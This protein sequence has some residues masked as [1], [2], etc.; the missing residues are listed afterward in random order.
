MDF[1][2]YQF[3]PLVLCDPACK[4]SS[5]S[6]QLW[7]TRFK[8]TLWYTPQVYKFFGRGLLLWIW[9]EWSNV[10]HTYCIFWQTWKPPH[11]LITIFLPYYICLALQK[12][13]C[14]QLTHSLQSCQGMIMNYELS[15]IWH[16]YCKF[17]ANLASIS[18]S[19]YSVPAI[20]YLL[21]IT[22][23]QNIDWLST[24]SPQHTVGQKTV[25]MFGYFRKSGL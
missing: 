12:K 9:L 20:S 14:T 25:P 23:R 13:Y 24:T 1:K 4:S 17:L 7:L 3:Q 5:W 6:E 19:S 8:F 16:A 10:W 11:N 18:Q 15:N 22:E 21:C 2:L